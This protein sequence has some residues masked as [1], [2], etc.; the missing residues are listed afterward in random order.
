MFGLV[1]YDLQR[2]QLI[3]A[4][5]R[6][7]IKPLYYHW[8]GKNLSFASEIKPILSLPWVTKEIDWQG[9][10]YLELLYV[11]APL[12]GFK[13]IRKLKSGSMLIYDDNVIKEKVYWKL[14]DYA[15]RD[16]GEVNIHYVTEKLDSLLSSALNLQLRS[17][18]SVGAFLSGG[19]DSSAVVAY[20]HKFKVEPI[21]T[22][23]AFWQDAIEKMDERPFANSVVKQYGCS[24]YETSI[25]QEDFN[26]LLPKV[27][28]HMEEPCAGG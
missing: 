28:W 2:K 1:I 11:P 21:Q 6:L 16:Y 27:M 3:L 14:N 7:G 18:V 15:P 26:R 13:D 19:V 9:I 4:R 22:F 25:S 5:D 12:T 23:I 20:A 24:H 8:D 17:D 10:D